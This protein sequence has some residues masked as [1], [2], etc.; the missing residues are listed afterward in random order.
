MH[1]LSSGM[2]ENDES[3]DCRVNKN[4]SI[5]FCCKNVS[6]IVYFLWQKM[7]VLYT[8]SLKKVRK[9]LLFFLLYFKICFI[10]LI[11]LKFDL[12]VRLNS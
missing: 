5:F 8:W 11:Y 4:P 2:A 1:G 9:H 6:N 3:D 12:V 7:V 10:I